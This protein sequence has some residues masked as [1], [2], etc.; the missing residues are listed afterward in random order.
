MK[1]VYYSFTVHWDDINVQDV[2]DMANDLIEMG[3]KKIHA[4]ETDPGNTVFFFS[5]KLPKEYL[6]GTLKL[7]E[8]DYKVIQSWEHSLEHEPLEE[9]SV[10][11][12][13]QEYKEVVIDDYH[14][15]LVE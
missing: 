1:K 4:I 6:E 8:R 5:E 12:I 15:I 10:E 11:S 14:F 13:L 2:A 7:G 3:A 9:Y